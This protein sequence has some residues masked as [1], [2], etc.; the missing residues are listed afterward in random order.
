MYLR[1]LISILVSI[2]FISQAT[3]SQENVLRPKSPA[4]VDAPPIMPQQKYRTVSFGIEA[5]L[6]YNMFSQDLS[7]SPEVEQSIF[8]V[9]E[10][11][12][13]I[14]GYFEAFIDIPIDN[15]EQ[16]YSNM[17]IQVRLGYEGRSYSN[18]YTGIV[19]CEIIDFGTFVEAEEK[20]EMDISGADIG[21]SALFRYNFSQNFAMTVGPMVLIPAGNYFQTLTETILS[22]DCYFNYGTPD[23]SKV[24]ISEAEIENVKTRFGLDIGFSYLIP[25]SAYMMLAPSVRLNYLFNKIGEDQSTVDGTRAVS[26]GGASLFLAE[27]AKLHHLKFGLAL[28]F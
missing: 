17:G 22:D 10:K 4:K 7:W 23:Q 12:S 20:L 11:A 25:I 26:N 14:S 13:G 3:F 18:S 21:L 6:N 1:L 19:D 5:G 24:Q 8:N 9:F 16:G 27:N 28:W 15:R 2:L